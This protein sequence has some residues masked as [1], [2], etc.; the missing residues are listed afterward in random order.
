MA[1]IGIFVAAKVVEYLVYP[2]IHPLGYLFNY[3]C[4]ITN[5]NQQIEMLDHA[6]VRRQQSVEEA[7]RQKDEIFP[8]VQEWLKG[9]KKI[10]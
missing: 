3:H 7:N 2:I 9:A 6:S 10:I 4:N 5:F 1:E 8:D